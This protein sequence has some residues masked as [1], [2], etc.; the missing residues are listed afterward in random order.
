MPS[1]H[2]QACKTFVQGALNTCVPCSCSFPGGLKERPAKL[3]HA[4]DPTSVLRRAVYGM[5][6][7]NK[8]RKVRLVRKYPNC[9]HLS[10]ALICWSRRLGLQSTAAMCIV[11]LL[12]YALPGM[13][14][15]TLSAA[16]LSELHMN[17]VG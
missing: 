9:F 1:N 12:C 8:L 15:G 4:K 17:V 16:C 13:Q 11:D 6:P 2:P 10:L 5:L 3:E 7:K 14:N